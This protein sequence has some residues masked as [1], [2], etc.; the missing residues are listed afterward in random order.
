M[1][2]IL[3]SRQFIFLTEKTAV[4]GGYLGLMQLGCFGIE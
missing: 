1:R 2:V 3:D 4:T